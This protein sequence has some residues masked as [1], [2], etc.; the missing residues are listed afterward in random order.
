M[1]QQRR[2]EI[3][4]MLLDPGKTRAGRTTADRPRRSDSL[5]EVRLAAMPPRKKQS[6]QV[7]DRLKTREWQK[8]RNLLF[9]GAKYSNVLS[10]MS[11]CMQQKRTPG[12]DMK[13]LAPTLARVG[14]PL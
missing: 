5:S 11:S 3:G 9:P 13:Y 1:E 2:N 8:D 12:E 14:D 10:R 6:R 4:A 7:E